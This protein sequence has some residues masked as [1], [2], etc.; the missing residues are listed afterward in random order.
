MMES[1]VLDRL[2][3][4]KDLAIHH[5]IQYFYLLFTFLVFIADLKKQNKFVIGSRTF[6]Y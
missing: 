1:R 4:W 2:S 5:V 6:N 3:E